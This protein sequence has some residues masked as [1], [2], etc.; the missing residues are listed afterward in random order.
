MISENL[1]VGGLTFAVQRSARRRTLELTIE[2]HG[3]LR[4]YAPADVSADQL[5][6]WVQ[7][8]LLWI[9]GKLAV[10][11][12]QIRQRPT[13]EFAAGESFSFLGRPCRLRLVDLQDAPLQFNGEM[14]F[15]RRDARADAEH[16]FRRWYR[17]NGLPWVQQRVRFLAPRVGAVPQRVQVRELGFRWGSCGRNGVLRF[18]W[19]LL[20]LPVQLVD[21][22]IVHELVHLVEPHHGPNFWACLERA[23]P[24]WY[25]RR[26]ALVQQALGYAVF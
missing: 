12:P 8:K 7:R 15:L 19:K 2:R 3:G 24:D 11:T 16:H 26:E 6:A 13:R 20:Q 14:F 25:E 5:T 21:Y 18:H 22:V 1:E 10:K 23:L 4:V 17:L 9:H